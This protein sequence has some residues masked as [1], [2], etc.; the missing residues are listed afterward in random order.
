MDVLLILSPN[1]LALVN[2]WTVG[3]IVA[4]AT[5]GMITHNTKYYLLIVKSTVCPEIML[6]TERSAA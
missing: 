5:A 2:Y 3:M 1:A 4:R 6:A